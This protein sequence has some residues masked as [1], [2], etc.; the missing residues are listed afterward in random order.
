MLIETHKLLYVLEEL[1]PFKTTLTLSLDNNELVLQALFR[2]D[3]IPY[4]YLENFSLDKLTEDEDTIITF[5]QN[6]EDFYKDVDKK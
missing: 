6:L 1:I 4:Y 3:E 2:K 5:I